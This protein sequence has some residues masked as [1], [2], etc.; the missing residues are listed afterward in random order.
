[1]VNKTQIYAVVLTEF[2]AAFW[3]FL[4]FISMDTKNNKGCLVGF[5]SFDLNQVL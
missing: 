2:L 3:S 5:E 1:M 4:H